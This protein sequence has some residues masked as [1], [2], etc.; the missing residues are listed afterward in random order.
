MF[1]VTVLL[2]LGTTKDDQGL[3]NKTTPLAG[4]LLDLVKNMVSFRQ[5]S[6]W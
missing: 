5:K 1:S 4:F 6:M 2:S 3:A